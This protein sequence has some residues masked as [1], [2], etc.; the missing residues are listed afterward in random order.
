MTLSWRTCP[1]CGIGPG[2]DHKRGCPGAVRPTPRNYSSTVRVISVVRKKKVR[3][4][5]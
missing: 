5:K 3:R 4:K 1:D 2:E